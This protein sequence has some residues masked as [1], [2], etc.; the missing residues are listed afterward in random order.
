MQNAYDTECNKIKDEIHQ[1]IHFLIQKEIEPIELKQKENR[2]WFYVPLG[3]F[4][5]PYYVEENKSWIAGI[6]L[7]VFV[8]FIVGFI[9][10]VFFQKDD[11]QK[12]I[13]DKYDKYQNLPDD[14]E[15]LKRIQNE[16]MSIKI[17]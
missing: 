2:M 9:L 10:S 16:V 5:I 11:K 3:F 6:F 15:Q 12:A 4:F 7:G 14:L 8:S 1:R 13:R 17:K